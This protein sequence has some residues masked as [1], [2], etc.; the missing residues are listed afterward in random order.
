MPQKPVGDLVALLQRALGERYT[1]EREIGRGGMAWV[2][3]A[4]DLKHGRQ[5]AIKTLRP[6]IAASLGAERFLREIR[7]AAT[8]QH[9]NILPLYDS[10]AANGFLYYVMPYVDGG[11]LRDRLER[12]GQLPVDEAVRI[13][14]EV[15]DAL[16]YAH[17]HDVVHRDIKP[18]NILFT[19][20][21]ALVADFGLARAITSA[22]EEKLTET[23]IAIGTPA[24]MSPEQASAEA[25]LD[26]RCD[27]YALGC[28]LYELLAGGPPFTGPSAQ[29]ILARHSLDPVPPLRTVRRTIP[30]WLEEAIERALAKAPADRFLTAMQFGESL[31]R[32]AAAQRPRWQV[33]RRAVALVGGA[34]LTIVAVLGAALLSRPKARPALDPNLVAVAPFDV[35][36][37]EHRLWREGMVDLLSATLDG[38]G[39]LRTVPAS[40]VVRAWSGRADPASAT[41]LG[42][43]SGAG[44][45]VYGRV[46][47]AGG[48]SV[49][50]MATL[51]DITTGAATDLEV[52]DLGS[53]LDRVA[54]SLAVRLIRELGRT[55][56]ITAVR[57]A[58]LGSSSVPALKAYLTGEHY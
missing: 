38:A 27:I 7:V 57:S 20:G 45:A 19:S 2:L 58:G 4:R 23:G 33:R 39:P 40:T 36:D 46:V 16:S 52:R 26:G 51:L 47:G 8:L 11:S 29:A 37:Q 41:V 9:P 5:V 30:E 50:I 35:L 56:P 49:R 42:R 31:A 1:I 43:G 54:D 44:V 53:R 28:V 3:L 17:R 15:A 10:G 34:A 24:Y 18:E 48:D 13:A 6:E 12:E 32:G 22:S 55:R 25:R 21:H 14:R